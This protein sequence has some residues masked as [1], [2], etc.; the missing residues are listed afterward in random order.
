VN[1]DT[2]GERLPIETIPLARSRIEQIERDL[3]SW[4]TKPIAFS[5]DPSDTHLFSMQELAR[6]FAKRSIDLAQSIRSLIEQDRIVPATVVARALI[7]TIGMGCL[8]LHEM[9]R[10]IALGDRLRLEKCFHRFYAGVKGQ[11]IEPVH[12]MDAIR[13][14]TKIDGEYIQYIENKYGV[15]T[16]FFKS[17]TEEGVV[18]EAQDWKELM[19]MERNYALLSEIAHPNGTG[20]QFLYPDPS[21]ENA[22]VTKLRQRF[23]SASLTAIW[24]CFHLLKALEDSD[25]LPDRFRTAFLSQ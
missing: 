25:D 17:A 14:L 19:S 15:F 23:R 24:H 9:G 4:A 13:H 10:L 8:Y 6:S 21:N 3:Q 11:S 20:I 1:N 18:D 5:F 12:V 22:S 7:E 2:T 16:S